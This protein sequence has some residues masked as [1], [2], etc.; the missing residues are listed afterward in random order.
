MPFGLQYIEVLTRLGQSSRLRKA[1]T[2]FAAQFPLSPPLWME[3]IAS[4]LDSAESGDASD[5]S[6]V[7]Q[8]C[9]DATQDYFSVDI[10][11]LQLECD[12]FHLSDLMLCARRCCVP[13]R[14]KMSS[15][16]DPTHEV[17]S[18]CPGVASKPVHSG[19]ILRVLGCRHT[20]DGT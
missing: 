7:L 5:A 11:L 9:S 1:R 15:A 2:A 3:W 8:L 18:Y 4:E 19:H 10:W 13:F 20:M 14:S 12:I 16:L 6:F 17:C